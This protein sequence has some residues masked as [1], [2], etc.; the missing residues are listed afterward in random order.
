ML[1]P[2]T[3]LDLLQE[4]L[5]RQRPTAAIL[6]L[7]TLLWLD[8][9]PADRPMPARESEMAKDA[10]VQSGTAKPPKMWIQFDWGSNSPIDSQVIH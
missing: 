1:K 5:I 10:F 3:N 7:Q 2:N 6:S 9:Y 4:N 8:S